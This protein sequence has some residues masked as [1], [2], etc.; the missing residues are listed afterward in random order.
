MADYMTRLRA[1]DQLARAWWKHDR[2]G[3]HSIG[4]PELSERKQDLVSDVGDTVAA[5]FESIFSIDKMLDSMV[6]RA[7]T[8]EELAFIGTMFLEE[9]AGD[10]GV[11]KVFAILEDMPLMSPAQKAAVRSGIAR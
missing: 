2:R 1:Y 9:A 11:D 7:R 4:G 5:L 10:L 3:W 8:D 6:R